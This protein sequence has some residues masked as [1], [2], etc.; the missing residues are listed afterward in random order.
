[1]LYSVLLAISFFAIAFKV[2]SKSLVILRLATEMSL[3]PDSGMGFWKGVLMVG[4]GSYSMWW[5]VG[6][7]GTLPRRMVRSMNGGVLTGRPRAISDHVLMKWR[8]SVPSA[9]VC[10]HPTPRHTPPHVNLVTYHGWKSSK[11]ASC[12]LHIY[13]FIDMLT[14]LT[15]NF[16]IWDEAIPNLSCPNF[17]W[18]IW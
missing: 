5:K 10:C 14:A 18:I 9:R 12:S 11:R 6:L 13:I 8:H 17:R 7:G 1:M 4:Y 2:L 16:G 15:K 3:E